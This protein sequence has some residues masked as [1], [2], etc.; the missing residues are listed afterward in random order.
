MRV[1]LLSFALFTAAVLGQDAA[2][3]WQAAGAND[4]RSPCP[5]LNSLANHGYLPRTGRNISV[6]ALI[7]GMHAGLNLRDDAKLFFRLQGNKALTASSTGDA[8]TFHLSDLITHDLIEHD[9]SLSRAD[10]HFGDNWSFNQTI[11]DE[12]KSYWPADLIS[13]SDAAKALVARQKTAKAVNP[14]FNLPLDGYTNSLGQTAMYLGLFG[15]YEDG[16][17]RTDWAVYF[18]ENE[19]LPFELGW[20]RR[21]DDDKIPATGILALTTKVAVH[22]LAAKI[23]L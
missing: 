19:R 12:T 11:F 8:Q 20:A 14:E 2:H 13:I 18:F 23:G 10:I 7:E 4:L 1:S 21:S 6:D 15:D 5:L 9:A 3:Q 17:A 16:N 22:Y